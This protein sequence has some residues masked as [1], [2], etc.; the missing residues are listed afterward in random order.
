MK[1][2]REQKRETESVR[3]LYKKWTTHLLLAT[4]VNAFL[5][6]GSSARQIKLNT[7]ANM[8][9]ISSRQPNRNSK[10]MQ[11]YWGALTTH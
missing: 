10:H 5:Q 7:S 1:S 6:V 3:I 4:K 9:L 11:R 2:N 8:Y